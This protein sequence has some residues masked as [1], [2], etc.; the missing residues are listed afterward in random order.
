MV[1][2]KYINRSGHKYKVDT[3][4]FDTKTKAE[5]YFRKVKG[6]YKKGEDKHFIVFT[7]MFLV[8]GKPKYAICWRG[9]YKKDPP[10]KDAPPVW[11]KRK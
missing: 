9:T 2:S 8:N 11:T 5:A 10:T 3:Q 1:H 7:K 4:R 6:E